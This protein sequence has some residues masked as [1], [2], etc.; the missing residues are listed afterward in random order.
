MVHKKDKDNTFNFE[1]FDLIIYIWRRFIP[2]FIITCAGAIVA[3]I[4]SLVI[5]EKYKATTTFFPANITSVSKEFMRDQI[6]KKTV[7]QFGEEEAAEK[8]LQIFKSTKLKNKIIHK[9]NLREHYGIDTTSKTPMTKLYRQYSSNIEAKRTKYQSVK[10]EVIDKDPEMAADIAN[11]LRKY[12]DNMVNNLKQ[13]RAQKAYNIVKDAYQSRK[14][15]M[16]QL[17]DSLAAVQE[18]GFLPGETPL[19]TSYKASAKHKMKNKTNEPPNPAEAY[20]NAYAEAIAQGNMDEARTLKNKMDSIASYRGD[21]ASLI[22]SLESEAE[23]LSLLKSRVLE[24]KADAKRDIP[25]LLMVDKAYTPDKK[26]YPIRWLIVVVSTISTFI[27][28]LLLFIIIDYFKAHY[29][30]TF[31]QSIRSNKYD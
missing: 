8:I 24:T 23:N 10:I 2:L 19:E 22:F 1:S 9:Y 30:E 11:D 5:E 12:V 21:Y 15:T 13:R 25:H 16:K 6:T 27:L 28:A 29:L 18:N 3:I 14:N 20:S 7:S 17:R 31:Q 26:A 4:V